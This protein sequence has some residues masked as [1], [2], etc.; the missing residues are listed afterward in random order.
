MKVKEVSGENKHEI[1]ID[2]IE[3]DDLEVIDYVSAVRVLTSAIRKGLE[4]GEVSWSQV[5]RCLPFEQK[6]IIDAFGNHV[7]TIATWEL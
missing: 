5:L 1:Y 3:I 4:D 7:E 6:E 2:D